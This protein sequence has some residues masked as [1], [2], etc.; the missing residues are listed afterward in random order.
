MHRASPFGSEGIAEMA[1]STQ[2][3]KLCDGILDALFDYNFESELQLQF[4][5]PP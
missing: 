1:G 3:G 2:R 4:Q 5:I